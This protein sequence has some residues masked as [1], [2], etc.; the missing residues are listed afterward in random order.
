MPKSRILARSPRPPG[1]NA[2]A[3]PKP[4]PEERSS[5]PRT[6][7]PRPGWVCWLWG[8][9][10]STRKMLPG[11]RSRWMTPASWA[12]ARPWST[13][14]TMGPTSL[15]G[16]YCSRLRRSASDSPESCSKTSRC[17]PSWATATSMSWQT[18]GLLM[19]DAMRASRS[20]R[21]TRSGFMAAR[22]SRTLMATSLRAPVSSGSLDAR[23]N[24]AHAAAPEQAR[25]TVA[26]EDIARVD[27]HVSWIGRV[28]RLTRT[29]CGKCGANVG[30]SARQGSGNAP[31]PPS[32]SGGSW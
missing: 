25:D 13:S 12:A 27:R 8:G 30:R 15:K 21:R 31:K 17:A 20:K 22:A 24:L 7:P 32:P 4:E 29:G 18:N 1:S 2:G 23:P 9:G 6:R 16:R 28:P 19:A 5:P 14:S 26:R 10:D 3:L 11:L